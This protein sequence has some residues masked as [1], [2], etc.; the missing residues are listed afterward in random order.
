[1]RDLARA[2]RPPIR[3]PDEAERTLAAIRA[4]YGGI[5]DLWS[6]FHDYLLM[7]LHDDLGM[8]SSIA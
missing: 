5:L 6:R 3:G 8:T 7:F 1:M 2:G 4:I